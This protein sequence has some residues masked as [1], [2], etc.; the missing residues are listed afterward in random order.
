MDEEL[1][2]TAFNR[3][4]VECKAKK[5]RELI[6]ARWTFN[7]TTVECKGRSS[8]ITPSRTIPFN[9][10]TVECKGAPCPFHQDET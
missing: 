5:T 10:T 2:N 6:R 8:T 7:R 1:Q 9:R 4:T 3:T